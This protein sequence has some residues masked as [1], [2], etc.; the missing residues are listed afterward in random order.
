MVFIWRSCS[1]F[2]RRSSRIGRLG[3]KVKVRIHRSVIID[4]KEVRLASYLASSTSLSVEQIKNVVKKTEEKLE[5]QQQPIVPRDIETSAHFVM[6]EDGLR[7]EADKF[8]SFIHE[9]SLKR[10]LQPKRIPFI[11][12]Q[13][14][15]LNNDP[16]N[17]FCVGCGAPLDRGKIEGKIV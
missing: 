3:T 14:C 2:C 5:K 16:S 12:C 7:N 17:K 6:V 13:F 15:N 10:H 8:L 9:R 11:K 1:N 4:F